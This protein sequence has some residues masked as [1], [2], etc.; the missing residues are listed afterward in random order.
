MTILIHVVR[1]AA[2]YSTMAKVV[3]THVYAYKLMQYVTSLLAVFRVV[4][5]DV[6]P[7]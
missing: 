5:P 4:K 3:R 7:S 1:L 6:I 2:L